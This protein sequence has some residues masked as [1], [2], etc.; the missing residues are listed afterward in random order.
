MKK[1][2]GRMFASFFGMVLFTL[3][4]IFVFIGLIAGSIASSEKVEKVKDGSVLEIKLS[5]PIVDNSDEDIMSAFNA[6]TLMGNATEKSVSLKTVLDAICKAK[7]DDKIKGIVIDAGL[8]SSQGIATMQEVLRNLRINLFMLTV[9]CIR[10]MDTTCQV[11][12]I[13]FIC[14]MKVKLL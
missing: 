2:F 1:F 3:V 9:K 7:N 10:K 13:K 6:A 12:P 8:G 11:L 4:S 14:K 5:Q